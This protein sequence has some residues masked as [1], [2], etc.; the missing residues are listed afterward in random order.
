MGKKAVQAFLGAQTI[1]ARLPLVLDPDRAAP[2]M[3]QFYEAMKGEDPKVVA[4]EV[5]EPV[6]S[7][8]GTWMPF[9]FQDSAGRKVTIVMGETETGCR[10][11]WENFAAFGESLWGDFCRTRPTAPKAMRVRIRPAENYVLHHPRQ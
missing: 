11:D 6:N 2:R 1:E 9:M 7:R 4:W 10:I 5:G 3:R 8:Y